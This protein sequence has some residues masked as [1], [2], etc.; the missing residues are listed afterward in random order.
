MGRALL[1]YI[2]H[3]TSVG[4]VVSGYRRD[5]SY[6]SQFDI[7]RADIFYSNNLAECIKLADIVIDF[8]SPIL[9]K[10]ILIEC[11]K[12]KKALVSGTTGLEKADITYMANL[13]HSI[14]IFWSPN[15]SWGIGV[16]KFLCERAAML[17]RNDFDIEILEKH[18]RNKI[19]CPSGTALMLAEAIA[20]V[21]TA[22]PQ[23]DREKQITSHTNPIPIVFSRSNKRNTEEIGISALRGG[24]LFGTH[25]IL[26]AGEYETISLEHSALNRILFVIGALRAATF[27]LSHP[28]GKLY[29]MDDVVSEYLQRGDITL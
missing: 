29:S 1:D 15:M 21:K 10:S 3:N 13:S 25:E 12:Y 14:R 17:L 11:I 27:L 28:M 5:I 19:D 2:N 26:F 24:G 4:R 20:K 6:T 18:H 22:S 9:L 8:S 23:K 16:L 7:E